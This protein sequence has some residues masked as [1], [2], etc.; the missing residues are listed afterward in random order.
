MSWEAFDGGWR[1]A[2]ADGAARALVV[3]LHGVGSNAQDLT[4]LADVWRDALPGV[5][6]ASLDGSEPFDGGFGGRQWFSLRDISETNREARVVAA[7][8]VFERRLEA[9]LA[10][11]GLGHEALALVGFSQGS[12]MSLYHAATQASGAAAVVAYAGRLVTPVVA[13]SHTALTLV[14]GEDDEVI[15]ASELERAAAAFSDAGFA[16]TAFALPGVGHTITPQG[17]MLGRDALVRA[18]ARESNG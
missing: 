7:S 6:F 13:R 8:Q 9:E 17:V 3:L 2:P 4:P 1:L 5:A 12:I 10:H 18:L 11:W 16:V 14:H 15:A